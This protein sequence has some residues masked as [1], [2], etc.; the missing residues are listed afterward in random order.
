MI[1]NQND[2]NQAGSQ[3]NRMKEMPTAPALSVSEQASGHQA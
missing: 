1:P 2:Q 3:E